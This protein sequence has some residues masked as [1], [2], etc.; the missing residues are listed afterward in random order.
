MDGIIPLPPEAGL[1]SRPHTLQVAIWPPGDW[2][3]VA[4][5]IGTPPELFCHLRQTQAKRRLYIHL[6]PANRS[7]SVFARSDQIV[8]PPEMILRVVIIPVIGRS[9]AGHWPVIGRSLAGHWFEAAF[10]SR[11]VCCANCWRLVSSCC[12]CAVNSVNRCWSGSWRARKRFARAP[13]DA[14]RACASLTA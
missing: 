6:D 9:L 4:I 2:L 12:H 3:R 1:N 10:L 7:A 13:P 8:I 14:R 11:W 5:V